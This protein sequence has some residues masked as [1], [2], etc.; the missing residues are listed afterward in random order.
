M[1]LEQVFWILAAL[2]RDS[3]PAVRDALKNTASGFGIAA[4]PVGGAEPDALLDP[5]CLGAGQHDA[6]P[7]ARVRELRRVEP[8]PVAVVQGCGPYR[9]RR[10]TPTPPFPPSPP[11]VRDGP[12]PSWGRR[13]AGRHGFR[14]PRR[15]PGGS[16]RRPD[17]RGCRGARP[18]WR[19][20]SA[21]SRIAPSKH[22]YVC[23]GCLLVQLAEFENAEF[24]FTDYLYYSSYSTSWLDHARS[25]VEDITARLGLN[26][27]KQVIEIASND[28]YLLQN[29]VAS[30]IPC[31]GIEPAENVALVARSRGIETRTD[32]FGTALASKLV[33]ENLSADLLIGNNVSPTYP[34]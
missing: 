6:P 7:P 31:L 16:V 10:Y 13:S 24:I 21:I 27:S 34:T 30:G 19:R 29:F 22:A 33:E 9:T 28:G 32:F 4:G 26:S 8:V 14:V 18:R 2:R 5:F 20:R 25:Y 3:E 1:Q 11:P 15:R 17:R 23:S 12:P